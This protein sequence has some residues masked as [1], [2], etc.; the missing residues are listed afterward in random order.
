L[1][2]AASAFSKKISTKWEIPTLLRALF[3]IALLYLFL[4]GVE[5]LGGGF[6]NLGKDLVDGLFEGV[7]NPVG[8]L[9]VGLL[10][11]VLV[12]SS[13]VSTS[14][15]VGLVAAG[16]VNTGDAVPM[17]MGANLGT[18]VTNTL[19][20]LGHVRHD[21]EFKRAFAA[22]TVHDFF[23]ILAVIV[24]LPIELI[25][26]YLSSTATWL[27][28]TLI[29][30]SGSDFKSPLKEAVKLPAKWVKELLS[31]MGS[32][33]DIKGVLMIAIGLLFIFISLAY[34]TKN[35]RLLVADRVETAINHALGAGSGMVAILLGAIITISVQSSS[36]TTSVLVPLAASGVLTLQNIYPVTLGANVGT[37]VT[38][39]LA[40]LATGS[41]AAV[42]VAIVHT[43]FNISGI[44][45]FYPFQKLRQIPINLANRIADIA[46]ERRS[47]ALAYTLIA[48]VIVPLLGVLI[49]R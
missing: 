3:V 37:T 4:T 22:A 46:V 15:I 44:I 7:S 35:M 29:G 21:I 6:K 34:I 10:A 32:H 48:F 17:I 27:T 2:T 24:F 39:L 43:L 26:G 16:V 40:S 25:T 49:L 18:T 23:N 8:G 31:S 1:K 42:T 33:G 45:V 41:P 20:S 12:Q 47:L 9:F 38:A 13:S 28:D 30:S 14:V 19:A 11:T 5:L 36:I